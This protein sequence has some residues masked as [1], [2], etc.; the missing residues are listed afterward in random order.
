[1]ER[2][3]DAL[4]A[5]IERVRREAAEQLA[6]ER[7]AWQVKASEE[8]REMAQEL[9]ATA[10]EKE[11]AIARERE[12]AAERIKGTEKALAEARHLIHHLEQTSENLRQEVFE[13]LELKTKAEAATAHVSM[14]FS[15]YRRM[16]YVSSLSWRSP[17]IR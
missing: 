17:F 4:R 7:D 16:V 12:A 8:K 10:V 14:S 15:K 11:R 5:E 2:E 9:V 6:R 13:A 1:M 3:R